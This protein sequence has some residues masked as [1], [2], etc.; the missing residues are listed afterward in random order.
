MKELP[1][2][3]EQTEL[4]VQALLALKTPEECYALLEDLCT[5]HEVQA[6]SQRLEVARLLRRHITY[7]EIA[8]ETGAST[9]TISRV[10]RCLT[11]GAGGYTTVMDRM[12]DAQQGEGNA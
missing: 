2:R 4:L 3:S 6:L 7:Q 9:A 10:N 12:A 11:Y 8:A 1:R 5:I